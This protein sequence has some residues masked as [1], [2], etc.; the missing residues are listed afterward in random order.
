MGAGPYLATIVA[1]APIHAVLNFTSLSGPRG[2]A[3]PTPYED[4]FVSDVAINGN[5]LANFSGV[6]LFRYMRTEH[7]RLTSV[8]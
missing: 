4:A 2:P 3:V 5:N 1:G 8:L 6:F 7:H